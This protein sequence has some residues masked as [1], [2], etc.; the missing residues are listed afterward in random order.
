[1][2]GCKRKLFFFPEIKLVRQ[3]KADHFYDQYFRM[4]WL[5]QAQILYMC[6]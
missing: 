2:P 5:K 1:M 6:F 3:Y 4:A